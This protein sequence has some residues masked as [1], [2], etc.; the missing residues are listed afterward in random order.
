MIDSVRTDLRGY[1]PQV[2]AQV[3]TLARAKTREN[4][5]GGA[6]TSY[7]GSVR[8]FKHLI[9]TVLLVLL[10]APWCGVL[11]LS[12]ALRERADTL[13]AREDALGAADEM[14]GALGTALGQLSDQYEMLEGDATALGEAIA[15]LNERIGNE[16]ELQSYQSA[17]GQLYPELRVA[18]PASYADTT[19]TV[20]L[21]FDDGPGTNTRAILDILKRY[22][23]KATFF[24]V[25]NSIRG[26]EELL[27]RTAEEGHTI[28]VHS[29]THVYKDIYASLEAFL[30]DFYLT[31][32]KVEEI[33][34]VKPEIFRFPGGSVNSYNEAWGNTITSEMLSRGYRYYDWN[35]GSNDVA[36]NA[37]EES[38]Y[39]LVLQQVRSNPYA[40]VLMHDGGGSRARTVSALPRI[41]ERLRAE[42]Y[43]FDRLTNEVKPT[44]FANTAY[45]RG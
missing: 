39:T 37:T 14:V 3:K 38:I 40:V 1:S 44:V 7:L 36:A 8:F 30:E 13:R 17:Y 20:Y 32:I 42:G 31:S 27:R 15:A 26:R 23:I 16:I 4:S 10:L 28:G 24:V 34:G 2:K 11:Y 29:Y 35:A 18:G 22:D 19:G 12:R 43:R 41:I 21:T 5:G 6:K 33:T 45:S 9:V 25:G